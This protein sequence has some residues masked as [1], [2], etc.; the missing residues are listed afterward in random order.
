MFP[1]Q[2]MPCQLIMGTAHKKCHSTNLVLLKEVETIFTNLKEKGGLTDQEERIVRRIVRDG[3]KLID[4][5]EA[6]KEKR[7]REREI[8]KYGR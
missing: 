7:I 3:V 2:L 1:C 6:E 8:E 5:Y 4:E